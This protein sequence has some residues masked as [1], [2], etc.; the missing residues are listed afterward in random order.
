MLT[1]DKDKDELTILV[2][3]IIEN[4]NDNNNAK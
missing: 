2:Y 1:P 4:D 3:E